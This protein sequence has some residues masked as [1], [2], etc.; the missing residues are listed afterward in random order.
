[1]RRNVTRNLLMPAL[2]AVAIA[3]L[4]LA[5]AERDG[6]WKEQ[7]QERF[8]ERRQALFERADLDEETRSALVQAHDEHRQA[9]RELHEQHRERMDEI[10]DEE[11]RDA[12]H[13]AKQEMRDEYHDQHRDQRR[14]AMQERLTALVD[15]WEL[16]DEERERLTELRE[17]LYADMQTLRDQEF[18]SR[19]A[20]REARQSL[21]DEHR[22]ALA[23]VLTEE[24]IEALQAFVQPRHPKGHDGHHGTRHHG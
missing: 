19:E 15:S 24:Q 4:S 23:E 5:A 20:R 18:D 11:Q 3:P 1:M 13:Q 2:L 7:R 17:S 10:L 8:E 12:L 6:E 9:L 21:R 14:E 22:E 16:S